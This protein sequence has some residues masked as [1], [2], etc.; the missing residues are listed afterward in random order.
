MADMGLCGG[1]ILHYER[2]AAVYADALLGHDTAQ[3]RTAF[4][5]AVSAAVSGRIPLKLLDLGCG[6]GRDLTAFAA[7]GHDVTGLE[8]SPSLAAIARQNSGCP[9]IETDLLAD[10]PHADALPCQAFDG[11]FANA[12][13]FHIPTHDLPQLLQRIA[14]CLRPGGIL[15]TCDPTG[16]NE[17]GWTDDRYVAFRHPNRWKSLARNSGFSLISEWRRPPG[18]PRREQNWL[19][20]L[21]RAGSSEQNV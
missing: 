11:V 13:L 19:A 14:G 9:V 16:M 18:R 5:M 2:R 17:E 15:F 3:C 10:W 8:G 12:V 7:A 4:L 20:T 1:T 6:P 21:W